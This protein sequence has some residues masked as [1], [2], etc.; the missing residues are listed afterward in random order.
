M[1]KLFSLTTLFLALSF[2]FSTFSLAHGNSATLESNGGHTAREEAEGEE[3]WAKLQNKELE[4]E[5]LSDEDFGALGEYFM[6][7][8]AGEQHEAM[9]TR[10]IQMIGEKGEGQMH[11]AMGKRMSGCE[12]NAPMPQNMMN[13][14]M[15][16]MMQ[17]MGGS[18]SWGNNPVFWGSFG[19]VGWIF[20]IL[21]WAFAVV[22]LVTLIRWLITYFKRV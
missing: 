10:M 14:G 1:K 9:N 19:W 16:G 17:M 2:V 22:G 3:I 20:M 21:F 18:W 8:M 6:G 12:P 7:L 4:C 13:N 5:G 11:V 15:M